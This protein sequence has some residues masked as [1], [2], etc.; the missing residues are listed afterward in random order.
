M[1]RFLTSSVVLAFGLTAGGMSMA[2]AQDVPGAAPDPTAQPMPAETSPAM[3]S[4]D[5]TLAGTANGIQVDRPAT[6][7]TGRLLIKVPVLISLSQDAVGKPVSVAPD[8]YYGVN[9]D[10]TVGLT[11]TNGSLVM[12]A[13]AGQGLCLTGSSNNCEKVYNNVGVDTL[14]RFVNNPGSLQ[15][16]SH[17]GA[18]VSRISDPLLA[19]VRLG[20]YG[21]WQS[22]L[23][24]LRFDPAVFVGLTKRDF[25]NKER[26]EIPLG[27]FFNVT[28]QLETFVL[29]AIS[30]QLDGFG[31]VWR[32]LLSFGASYALNPMV[33]LGAAIDLPNL[34]G[35]G[36]TADWRQ[37]RLF[38]NFRI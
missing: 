4:T 21:E 22:G 23:F 14:Y 36:G 27:A 6:L 19:N 33:D 5:G 3:T 17:V 31:D 13:F 9:D 20:L 10:F 26:L 34:Y 30:G 1:R 24:E 18:Y 11:H 8:V 28:P 15:L 35:K 16:A 25:G 12:P 32:G 29:T 37:L 2:L 38:A 7:E